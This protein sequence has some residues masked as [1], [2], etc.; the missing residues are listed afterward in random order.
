MFLFDCIICYYS[1]SDLHFP[2][3]LVYIHTTSGNE[4]HYDNSINCTRKRKLL[5]TVRHAAY[6]HLSMTQIN[7]TTH[8][9]ICIPVFGTRPLKSRIQKL[10]IQCRHL[11]VVDGEREKMERDQYWNKKATLIW[12]QFWSYTPNINFL[13]STFFYSIF[14]CYSRGNLEEAVSMLE[15]KAGT[16]HVWLCVI[17][18]LKKR[19]VLAFANKERHCACQK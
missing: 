3:I 12:N 13:S 7:N 8:Q 14:R 5:L 11:N 4:W 1:P 19:T 17:M 16:L 9:I 2:N 6:H 10:S 18:Y 15:W